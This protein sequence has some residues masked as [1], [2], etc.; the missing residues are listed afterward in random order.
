MRSLPYSTV[1]QPR[2]FHH[3]RDRVLAALTRPSCEHSLRPLLQRGRAER[4]VP[5]APLGLMPMRYSAR[6]S[7]RTSGMPSK[8][9]A[10]RT[11]CSGAAVSGVDD[12]F[13]PVTP[14]A[15]GP[16][17]RVIRQTPPR[18]SPVVR[19]PASVHLKVSH[20]RASGRSG[21]DPARP[22]ANIVQAPRD[23]QTLAST[24]SSPANVT[25]ALAP[26]IGAGRRRQ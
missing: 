11:R 13:G 23:A 17:D 26:L 22:Q 19:D 12:P 20:L 16:D 7:I 3:P 5:C 1:K 10:F 14:K 4:R 18:G 25:I 2:P 9:P 6:V 24:A 8:C 21:K 15:M